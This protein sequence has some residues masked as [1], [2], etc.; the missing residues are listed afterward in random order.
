[1]DQL[2]RAVAVALDIVEGELLGASTHHGKRIA[3][4]SVAMGKTFGMDDLSLSALATCALLHDSALTEYILAEREGHDPAMKLHCQAGQHNAEALLFNTNIEGFVLYHHERADGLGPFG[5]KEGEFPREAALIAI[6]DMLDVSCHLQ[7]IPPEGLAGIRQEL[8][9]GAGTQYTREAVRAMLDVLDESMLASLGDE[10]IA[11]TARRIIPEWITPVTD[12]KVF[13]IADLCA[14]I[15]DYKSVF[16]KRHS[17]D[18]ANRAWIMGGYYGYDKARRAELYLAA[19][20][21]DIGK[22]ATPGKI[23][24]KPGKLSDEEFLIIQDHVRRTYDLLKGIKGFE[25]I[26]NTAS[27][28]HERL[29]GTGYPFGLKGDQLN[30]NDRL[31]AGIDVYQAV[32][33]E[34]PYHGRRSHGET[35]PVLYDMANADALDRDVVGDLDRVMAEFSDREVPAPEEVSLS[36]KS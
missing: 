31:L 32:S 17:V 35:M 14:R 18:I 24:E 9:R 20:L 21:H 10:R 2:V 16:T 6:A 19:A 25:D 15:I 11:D 33:E 23:L 3:V 29:N 4:L 7:R 5:K 34:R 1:M 36:G 8:R 22:L 30:F 27:R 12:E 13:R 28:H 26:C